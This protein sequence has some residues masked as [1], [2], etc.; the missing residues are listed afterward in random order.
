MERARITAALRDSEEQFRSA[1]ENSPVGILVTSV[2]SGDHGRIV[3]ANPALCEMI[4][5]SEPELVPDDTSRAG[6]P[7]RPGRRQCP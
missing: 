7:R 5:Y 4:G 2:D 3:K 1:F 6:P